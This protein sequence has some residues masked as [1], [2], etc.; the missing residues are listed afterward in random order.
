MSIT[1]RMK[2]IGISRKAALEVASKS[3]EFGR[4]RSAGTRRRGANRTVGLLALGFVLL[5]VVAGAQGAVS[6]TAA[7]GGTNIS[8]DTAQNASLPSFT[9]LGNIVITET[10]ASDF[11]ATGTLIL[12]APS[13]WRFNTSATITATGAKDSGAGGNELTAIVTS[14]TPSSLT[15]TILVGGTAQINHL[16]ISGLQVQATNGAALPSSGNIYRATANPG[17]ASIN[18]ITTTS[19]GS[20]S[21]GSN[22]GSLSQVAGAVVRLGFT[23]Q[24]GS[25]TAGAVFGV[26]PVVQ[27]QDQFGN[28]SITGLG[29]TVNVAVSLT[30]GAGPLQGTTTF[31]IGTTGGNGT[32]SYTNLRIDAAGTG[33]QLTATAAGLTSALSSTF[34]VSAAAASQ[35]VF[36]QQPGNATAGTAIAPPVTL[37]LRDAFGNNVPSSGVSV[38]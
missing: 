9:T 33:K 29:A 10:A 6:I 36:V 5:G 38:A 14:L 2:F 23:T 30:S 19:N 13:G 15:I 25:A 37:Q 28:N 20:G 35:L 34:A 27:T 7:T 18:G 32:V 16:T 3:P 31:N 1:F 17:T 26:Q 11:S 12:T 21:G 8:A 24:P 22:F 4:T